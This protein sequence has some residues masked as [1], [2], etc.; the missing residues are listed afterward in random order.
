MSYACQ[1][2]K[3]P[4]HLPGPGENNTHKVNMDADNSIKSTCRCAGIPCSYSRE[5]S[6][7]TSFTRAHVP[8][9]MLARKMHN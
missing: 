4:D 2:K 7:S 3:H 8:V 5:L 6:T 1:I 9:E